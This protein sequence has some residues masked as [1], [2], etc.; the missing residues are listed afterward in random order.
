L[1]P[2]HRSGVFLLQN[3]TRYWDNHILENMTEKKTLTQF[4][5]W[6]SSN[7]SS[8]YLTFGL[9]YCLIKNLKYKD[10]SGIVFEPAAVGQV[11]VGDPV[12][13]TFNLFGGY[14]FYFLSWYPGVYAS[15]L[16]YGV[17]Q[18]NSACGYNGMTT[19]HCIV[20]HD[21]THSHQHIIFD[22]ASVY[23]GQVTNAYTITNDG[24]GFFVCAVDNYAILNIDLIADPD[25]IYIPPDNCVEPDTALISNDY[26]ANNGGIG[27]DKAVLTELWMDSFYR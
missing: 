6:P 10:F 20:H 14:G 22:C 3:L 12:D 9:G 8:S 26:V 17:F 27:G 24:A 13:L 19:N 25:G 15:G 1:A 18:N 5:G 23:N 2:Y 21:G 16:Y 4:Q 7:N 11:I